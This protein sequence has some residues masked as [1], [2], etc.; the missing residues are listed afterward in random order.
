MLSQIERL[1]EQAK[2]ILMGALK[3]NQFTLPQKIKVFQQNFDEFILESTLKDLNYNG[4]NVNSN[5]S[6]S[7][8]MHSVEQ[9]NPSYMPLKTINSSLEALCEV[10]EANQEE[11]QIMRSILFPPSKWNFQL[12]VDNT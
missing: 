11:E 4:Y 5:F 7:R 9:L 6:K 10:K 12:V 3:T 8:V 2:R 1:Q